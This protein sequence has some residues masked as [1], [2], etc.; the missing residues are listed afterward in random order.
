MAESVSLL[1]TMKG[2]RVLGINARE[3]RFWIFAAGEKKA[4][5]HCPCFQPDHVSLLAL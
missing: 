5:A 3:K 1:Q 4:R 2:A